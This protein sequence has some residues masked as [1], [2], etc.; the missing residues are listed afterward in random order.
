MHIVV[1]GGYGVFGSRLA[2]MLVRDGHQITI[3]GRNLSKAKALSDTLG[4]TPML[5]DAHTHPE[6]LL[7]HH[8]DVV[9][10]AAG[11]FHTRGTD[12]YTLAKLCLDHGVGYLDLS[13]DAA[14]T[15]GISNLHERASNQGGRLISGASSVPGLSSTIAAD[16]CKGLDT[17]L[18][19]E[20]SIVPGNRAP[21]GTSVV[22]SILG[23]LGTTIRTWR[24]GAWHEQAAWQEPKR[25]HLAPGF[26]RTAR[27]LE[28]PDTVLFPGFFGARSVVF[29]AGMELPILTWGMRAFGALRKRWP[30]PI[31]P[32]VARTVRAIAALTLPFGSDRG[33]M[34]VSVVG[35]KEGRTLRRTWTLVAQAGDG[36]Y[37][38]GVVARALLHDWTTVAPGAG[39]CLA[40]ASKEQVEQAMQDLAITTQ[41]VETPAPTLFEQGLGPAWMTMP[42]AVRDLHQVHDR[43]AFSGTASVVRGTSWM[44]RLAAWCFRFPKASDACP[45][46]VVKTKRGTTETWERTFNGRVFRSHC[47]PAQHPQHYYERFGPLVF[48]VQLVSN[49]GAIQLPV[50]R[51]WVLGW[52]PI[53]RMLLP[54]SDTQE[55]AHNG[56]FRFDVRLEAPLGG[57]LIVHYQGELR[58]EGNAT[59]PL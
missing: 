51:G 2:E 22:T 58:P 47:S 34:E 18:L 24:G 42:Q 14:F 43:Q 13:D 25:V 57:G 1:L 23:Q 56:V 45:V 55:S 15:A 19:I 20:V 27:C 31:T 12:P 10:D 3:A 38:P 41:T 49:N 16:L 11:P 9:V 6:T 17:V 33:G 59:V 36:P 7:A 5:C 52:L 30:F 53:P 50:L 54:K 39:P 48:E 44:G 35:M 28:V 29:R 8:P 37:V 21:R 4:A 26:V 32:P 40:I 46:R